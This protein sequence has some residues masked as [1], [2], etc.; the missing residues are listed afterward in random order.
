MGRAG[1]PREFLPV[2]ARVIEQAPDDHDL[3]LL[4]AANCAALG[5]RT[6][7]REAIELLPEQTRSEP[8]VSALRSAIDDLQD[9][10]VPAAHRRS[11]A[12]ANLRALRTHAPE[13]AEILDESWARWVERLDGHDCFMTTDGNLVRRARDDNLP[14]WTASLT[15]H[16]TLAARFCEERLGGAEQFPPPLAIE[17]M[18]PPWLAQRAH[19]ALTPNCVGYA[20]PITLLQADPF[21]CLDGLSA[22]DLRQVLA[23]PRVRVFVGPDAAAR[24]LDDALGRLEEASMGMAIVT[25]GTRTRLS[26]D[27]QT[28]TNRWSA[29]HAAA[30]RETQARVLGRYAPR[31]RAWW[32]A[33]YREAADGGPPLRVLVLTSRYSTFIRHAAEDLASALRRGGCDARVAMEPPHSR[34]TPLGQLR[35]ADPFEPDL[36]VLA[37]YF[38]TDAGLPFP[39]QVP[40][41]CWIQDAME[42]QFAER[43]FSALDFVMGHLHPELRSRQGFPSDRA[44]SFPVVASP[45][46]FHAGPISGAHRERFGCEIAYVSHQSE[47]PD[48]FHARKMGEEGEPD[49]KRVFERIRH[50]IEREASDPLGTS[51]HGR[52]RA[53]TCGAVER[54]PH[55][56][57]TLSGH[58]FR[59]YSLPLA[60]RVLRHQTLAWAAAVCRRRG[61]RL[62]IFG[63][64]WDMHPEL[65]SFAAGEIEHGED[66]RAC[67]QAAAVHLHVSVNTMVHQ[68][69]MECALSGGLPIGRLTLDAVHDCLGHAK[70]EAVLHTQ[71]KGTDPATGDLLYEVAASEPLRNA[72]GLR[73]WLGLASPETQHITPGQAESFRRPDHPAAGG[74]HAAWLFGDLR[75]LSIRTESDLERVTERAVAEPSWRVSQSAAIAERVME[76]CSTDALAARMLGL[77]R[78]SLDNDRPGDIA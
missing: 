9:D 72:R 34:P 21:E 52:L 53:L 74:M 71:P 23:D 16:R 40:W 75:E 65:S 11:T 64:G 30:L 57:D 6:L 5:L 68:R 54:L 29:A 10:K 38:R 18:D 61:W 46:K 17:G 27:A 35:W 26:P 42:H 56:T 39:E 78:A 7:A 58:V 3:R 63:R 47:T 37:N 1:R 66:L 25:P 15:D 31:D 13:A 67:Y 62:Q 22:C 70:R 45:E 24:W 28:V 12:E 20:A 48:A 51:L 49:V 8:Q 14:H 77:V 76:R 32:A 50:E 73:E 55:G 2:A 36:I 19:Q 4:L 69:V 60:D 33:R 43:Q 41:V 59:Q 44:L